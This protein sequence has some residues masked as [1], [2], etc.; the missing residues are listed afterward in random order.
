VK[1]RL[2]RADELLV[3]QLGVKFARYSAVSV[4]SVAVTQAV[5]LVCVGVLRWKAGE[6]N[7]C[8]VMVGAVPAYVLNRA[9][10]WQRRGPSD[11]VREILPFWG[12]TLAGLAL[13]TAMVIEVERWWPGSAVAASAA[14]LAS[15]GALWVVKFAVLDLVLFRSEHAP[16]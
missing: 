4:V 5:L 11:L 2:L 3:R 13:S 15:F 1:A 14:N 9:W 10:A 6:A 7:L 8:A 12:M 16:T